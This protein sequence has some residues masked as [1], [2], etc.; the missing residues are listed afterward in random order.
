M[1]EMS[2]LKPGETVVLMALPPGLLDG[3]P[4]DD[5]RAIKAI[6]GIRRMLNQLISSTSISEPD[7]S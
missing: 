3:L 6:V 4:A 5:Q 2:T 7:L 1:Y